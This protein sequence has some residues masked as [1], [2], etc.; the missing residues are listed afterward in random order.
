MSAQ[1]DLLDLVAAIDARDEAVTRVGRNAD[2]AWADE[3][4]HLIWVTATS[5][6]DMTTDDIWALLRDTTTHEPRA[7]GALMKRAAAEGWIAA[8]DTYRPSQRV[9]CHARPVRVWRSLICRGVA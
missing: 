4:M 5:S 2:P 1:G 8:T 9:A 3:V 7:L 6:P